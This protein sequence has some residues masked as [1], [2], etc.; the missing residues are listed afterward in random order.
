MER[1]TLFYGLWSLLVAGTFASATYYGYSPFADGGRGV[2]GA[3]SY[4]PTHK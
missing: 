2:P 3:G 1:S 4:G